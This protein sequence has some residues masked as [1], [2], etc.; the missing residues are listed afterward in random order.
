MSRASDL[1]SKYAIELYKY[2][3]LLLS[4]KEEQR[5][6]VNDMWDNW[7][8]LIDYYKGIRECR[9]RYDSFEEAVNDY[10]WYCTDDTEDYKSRPLEVM[11]VWKDMRI[12][13]KKIGVAKAQLLKA[14]RALAQEM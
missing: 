12:Y 3:T 9:G 6:I 8:R 1:A 11:E 14:W 7:A 5:R 13:K 10:D 4:A 2:R